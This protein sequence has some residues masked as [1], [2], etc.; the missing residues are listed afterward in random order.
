MVGCDDDAAGDRFRDNND[1]NFDDND[2]GGGGNGDVR[3]DAGADSPGDSFSGDSVRLGGGCVSVVALAVLAEAINNTQ[4]IANHRSRS[5]RI[6]ADL[7][8]NNI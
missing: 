6:A 2:N 4:T 1:D 7:R 8:D 3:D 5:R